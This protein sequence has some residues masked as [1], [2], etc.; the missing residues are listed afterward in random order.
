MRLPVD[1]RYSK[2]RVILGTNLTLLMMS[3]EMKIKKK[4]SYGVQDIN[5][6]NE[7]CQFHFFLV[8]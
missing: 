8:E 5:Y 6:M 7:S 4:V 1:R 3:S 2:A